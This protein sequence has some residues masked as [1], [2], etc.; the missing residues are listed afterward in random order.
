MRVRNNKELFFLPYCFTQTVQLNNK[1]KSSAEVFPL[2]FYNSNV[3]FTL[4]T[5]ALPS[6]KQLDTL[7]LF[8]STPIHLCWLR[9]WSG[10]QSTFNRKCFHA[11]YNKFFSDLKVCMACFFCKKDLLITSTEKIAARSCMD[12]RNPATPRTSEFWPFMF[13]D[14]TISSDLNLFYY[15]KSLN[16]AF[17]IKGKW[18]MGFVLHAISCTHDSSQKK[19]TLLVMNFSC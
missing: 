15:I 18:N 8:V 10:V 6:R 11:D 3:S 12:C 4:R 5:R 17:D 1:C 19:F 9:S 7:G 14:M 16:E 13:L 2:L